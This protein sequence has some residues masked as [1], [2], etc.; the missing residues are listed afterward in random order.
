MKKGSAETPDVIRSFCLAG[1]STVAPY[2]NR[3]NIKK[4]ELT[5]ANINS[6]VSTGLFFQ[7]LQIGWSQITFVQETN[8]D[9]TQG[10]KS[11]IEK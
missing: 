1:S 2:P 7:F 9:T 6:S 10:I 5:R 4:S 3:R 11:S 8:I